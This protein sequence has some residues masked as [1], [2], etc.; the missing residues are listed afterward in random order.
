MH[1]KPE[2]NPNKPAQHDEMPADSMYTVVPGDT[3]SGIAVAHGIQSWQIL[4]EANRATIPDPNLIY[5]G[6]RIS[7]R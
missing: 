7:L 5:P 4:A 1:A 6:Q 2:P 3:L